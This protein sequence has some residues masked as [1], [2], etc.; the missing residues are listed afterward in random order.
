M[1]IPPDLGLGDHLDTGQPIAV[2]DAKRPGQPKVHVVD[3]GV[4][5]A[6]QCAATG[7]GG[8]SH[9][10]A[11]DVGRQASTTPRADSDDPSANCTRT[12]SPLSLTWRTSTRGAP[13]A[14]RRWRRQS[15]D[16]AAHLAQLAL[17]T[18]NC[19]ASIA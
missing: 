3:A 9:S 17:K 16:A 11:R 10:R 5:D 1:V 13:G 8:A 19:M 7:A 2:A 18:C 4:L 15:A 12:P 14:G 6:G